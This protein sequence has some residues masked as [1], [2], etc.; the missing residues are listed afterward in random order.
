MFKKILALAATALC[1]FDASAGYVQYNFGGPI[2][3]YFVQHDDD[4]SLAYFRFLVPIAG[5]P[6]ES[7]SHPYVFY[8]DFSP[9]FGEGVDSVY[10]STTNF[11]NNG[12]ANLIGHDNFGSDHDITLRIDFARSTA[13]AFAYTASYSGS[14]Y[15]TPQSWHGSGTLTG[16]VTRGTVD[17]QL[18][19]TLDSLGGYYDGMGK[20][21]PR[22]VG[23]G[24]V[25]EPGSLALIAI[26]ALAATGIARRRKSA[27]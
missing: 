16:L 14:I 20:S 22:Y 6:S 25:P 21:V 15:F 24:D 4:Q 26:G 17:P 11:R 2:S 13:G 9:K 18:V 3:G 5:T 12:P 1:S 10:A 27:A 23:P 8:N 19:Q 7:T